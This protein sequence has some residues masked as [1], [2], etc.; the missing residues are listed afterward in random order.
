M[1]SGVSYQNPSAAMIII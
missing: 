1:D